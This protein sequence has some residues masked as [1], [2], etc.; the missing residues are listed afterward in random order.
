MRTDLFHLSWKPQAVAQEFR[1]CLSHPAWVSVFSR[2][3]SRWRCIG[4]LRWCSLFMQTPSVSQPRLA[5]TARD[6][7]KPSAAKVPAAAAKENGDGCPVP[8]TAN[9]AS[10][11]ADT[12]M[13]LSKLSP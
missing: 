9:S 2:E 11:G 4:A 12:S 3:S 1:K 10:A 13:L 8:V 5:I 7:A 6:G